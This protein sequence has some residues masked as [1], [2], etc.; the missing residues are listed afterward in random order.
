MQVERKP[1]LSNQSV[2]HSETAVSYRGNLINITFLMIYQQQ[3]TP[4]FP[5]EKWIVLIHKNTTLN[6]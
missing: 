3:N 5:D 1:K 2:D 4:T 6:F